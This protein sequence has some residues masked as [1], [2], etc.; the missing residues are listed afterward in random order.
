MAPRGHHETAAVNLQSTTPAL[1]TPRPSARRTANQPDRPDVQGQRMLLAS[2]SSNP[3]F[4]PAGSSSNLSQPASRLRYARCLLQEPPI[5]SFEP[6][7]WM[8]T[9]P[10]SSSAS[11]IRSHASDHRADYC[12]DPPLLQGVKV[13]VVSA[14]VRRITG[15]SR[16]KWEIRP[17]VHLGRPGL[18]TSESSPSRNRQVPA[19]PAR[20]CLQQAP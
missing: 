11:P 1:G 5:T 13:G 6:P 20:P 9:S 16:E 19:R 15:P 3:Q 12:D 14:S 7:P 18:A 2:P 17:S 8:R 4:M 10:N